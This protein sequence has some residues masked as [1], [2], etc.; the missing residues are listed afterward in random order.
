MIGNRRFGI[1]SNVRPLNITNPFYSTG[2]RQV[3]TVLYSGPII[4]NGMNSIEVQEKLQAQKKLLSLKRVGLTPINRFNQ[5]S[6]MDVDDGGLASMMGI[7]NIAH[8]VRSVEAAEKER[9]I[10]RK[11]ERFNA[12]ILSLKEKRMKDLYKLAKK[13]LKAEQEQKAIQY[14]AATKELA[15]V[16]PELQESVQSFLADNDLLN[17]LGLTEAGLTRSRDRARANERVEKNRIAQQKN[18]PA[19]NIPGLDLG[20]PTHATLSEEA[21]QNLTEQHLN[22][23]VTNIPGYGSGEIG[24]KAKPLYKLVKPFRPVS[25]KDAENPTDAVDNQ[26]NEKETRREEYKAQQKEQR[27]VEPPKEMV[28]R[29]FPDTAEPV[30]LPIPNIK[31]I[32]LVPHRFVAPIR[33]FNTVGVGGRR[34]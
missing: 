20:S 32:G 29:A 2:A 1:Q 13:R 6:P 7:N 34:L 23:P 21:I 18:H 16:P 19:T 5:Q 27:G 25:I 30:I 4:R 15:D 8:G 24:W 17:E 33:R 28:K 9:D 10:R 11:V 31:S 14:I 22:R 3:A 26:E 12:G